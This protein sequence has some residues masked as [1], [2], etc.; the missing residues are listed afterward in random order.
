MKLYVGGDILS[1]AMSGVWIRLLLH[2]KPYISPSHHDKAQDILA[3]G[4]DSQV[5]RENAG[6]SRSPRAQGSLLLK[7]GVLQCSG[8]HAGCYEPSTVKHRERE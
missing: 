6:Q 1:L 4:G 2:K 8:Q 7:L 3:P 5:V